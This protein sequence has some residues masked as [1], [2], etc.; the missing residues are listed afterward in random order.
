[1]TIV[2]AT[3]DPL[4]SD[5]GQPHDR[6]PRRAVSTETLRQRDV[7]E[8]GDHHVISEEYAVLDRVGRLQLPRAHVEA[9]GLERRVRLTLEDDHISVWPDRDRPAT[10][11]DRPTAERPAADAATRAARA[12]R[13]PLQHAPPDAAHWRRPTAA[14]PWSRRIGLSRDYPM[15]GGVVHAVRDVEHP[16]RARAARRPPR[17]IRLGQDDLPVDGR[18]RSTGRRAA[19]SRRRAVGRRDLPE[20]ELI[21]FRRRKIGFI[22]QAFGLMPILSAAENV[23]VPLRLVAADPRERDERVAGCSSWSALATAPAIGRTSCPAASSSASRS[24]ARSPTARTCSSPTSRPASSIRATGQASWAC[25]GP[26]P[27][28]GPHRHRRDPRPDAH[29]PR[30]P[31]HRAARRPG[32]RRAAATA[33]A[34][35]RHRGAAMAQSGHA[36][37]RRPPLAPRQTSAKSSTLPAGIGGSSST[38][39]P[40]TA[41][42]RFAQAAADPDAF[43]LA[44]D[45]DARSMAETSRRAAARPSRGGLPNI[46]FARR[47]ASSTCRTA[48]DGLA[49]RVDGPLPV[50][51]AAARRARPRGRRSRRPSRVSSRRTGASRSL[52]SIV[53]RD[54]A[55]HRRQRHVRRA[56][57]GADGGRVRGRSAST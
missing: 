2:V 30:R 18:R 10:R 55:R 8:E 14:G 32:G 36:H 5:A 21:E 39:A 49:D 4:V 27:E 38:S 22:F 42:R 51:L 16:G 45:A 35:S 12:D 56:G 19:P 25:S 54:R 46:V 40:A 43:V 17:P 37:D 52:L 15:P 50:G 57:P 53:D 29:R 20:S 23:E 13:Q 41:G 11:R 34:R 6:D 3:H 31:R 28:R 24:P 7:T 48:L 33:E 1:M 44:I 47:P 9:L 26:R